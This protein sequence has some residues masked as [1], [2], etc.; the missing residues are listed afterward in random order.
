M[1][2]SVFEVLKTKYSYQLMDD[3][4]KFLIVVDPMILKI[5]GIVKTMAFGPKFS[6]NKTFRIRIKDLE[7]GKIEIIP[8]SGYI[9]HEQNFYF[10]LNNLS[11][12]I[13]DY[14]FSYN[15]TSMSYLGLLLGKRFC[16]SYD[17]DAYPALVTSLMEKYEAQIYNPKDFTEL[18]M[19]ID[20]IQA[21][22]LVE[23]MCGSIPPPKRC[24]LEKDF[25]ENKTVY[26]LSILVPLPVAFEFKASK[27]IA[28]FKSFSW[29][30]AT[31]ARKQVEFALG[32]FNLCTITKISFFY[33]DYAG[34]L[35]S[36]VFRELSNNTKIIFVKEKIVEDPKFFGG[37]SIRALIPKGKENEEYR[38]VFLQRINIIAR[39]LY[40]FK[41]DI[42]KDLFSESIKSSCTNIF[43]SGQKVPFENGKMRKKFDGVE[44]ERWTCC[45]IRD[46]D[47][48]GCESHEHPCHIPS[49]EGTPSYFQVFE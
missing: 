8:P 17:A 47:D 43:H 40:V 15:Q 6:G 37:F 27:V 31:E 48:K 29:V 12:E 38:S 33:I 10:V 39:S 14:S 25:F 21:S 49:K 22:L 4:R 19:E 16:E 24:Q 34:A 46:I 20:I 2:N 28:S 45:G 1:E 5:K 18:P 13:V 11:L 7:T 42:C 36:T 26:E 3:N 9:D 32:I 30:S 44:K 41:C 35:D 23:V